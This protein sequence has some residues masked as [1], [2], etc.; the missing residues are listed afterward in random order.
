M[1]LY[2]RCNHGMNMNPL[3]SHCEIMSAVCNTSVRV[4]TEPWI[5]FN[6]M[7]IFYFI[8]EKLAVW[9]LTLQQYANPDFHFSK[10]TWNIM[11]METSNLI[12]STFLLWEIHSS[13]QDYQ[14]LLFSLSRSWFSKFFESRR[15][16]LGLK[17]SPVALK[18]LSH[19]AEVGRGVLSFSDK[20]QTAWKDF[21]TSMVSSG[22]AR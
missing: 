5:T 11:D 15:A 14:N 7:C 3:L 19:A 13:L 21:R 4:L 17:I 22:H 8:S 20:L 2:N 12:K 10:R 1:Y 9:C 18:S 16:L 6:R